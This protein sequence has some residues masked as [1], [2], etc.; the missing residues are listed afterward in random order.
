[1]IHVRY[2]CWYTHLRVLLN[3]LDLTLFLISCRFATR[4]VKLRAVVW[5]YISFSSQIE[6]AH[7]AITRY[8]SATHIY[9]TYKKLGLTRTKANQYELSLMLVMIEQSTTHLSLRQSLRI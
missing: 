8:Y 1:M 2:Q 6:R 7:R 3:L 5:C 9:R 4:R